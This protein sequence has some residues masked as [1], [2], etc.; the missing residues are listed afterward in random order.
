MK[1]SLIICLLITMITSCK[2]NANS[3]TNNQTNSINSTS[4]STKVISSSSI[5]NSSSYNEEIS[6]D[7]VVTK[8]NEVNNKSYT[9]NYSYQ[10]IEFNDVYVPDSYYYN[11]LFNQGEILIDLVSNTKYLYDF[12]IKNSKVNITNQSYNVTGVQGNTNLSK[13]NLSNFDYSILKENL[14]KDD[15]GI[16][17][18]NQELITFF[19]EVINDSNSFDYIIFNKINDNLIIDFYFQDQ[20]FDGYSYK[21]INVGNSQ[22]ETVNNYLNTFTK[23]NTKASNTKNIFLDNN[24]VIKGDIYF[25][26]GV[27]KTKF[28]SLENIKI[29]NE[30]NTKYKLE[31]ISN[32]VSYKQYFIKENNIINKIGLD[33]TNNIIS[34][35]TDM[36]ENEVHPNSIKFLNDTYLIDNEYVYLGSE[37]NEVI[38]SLLINSSS[39]I[40]DAWV[41]EI[42]FVIKDNQITQF[43]FTTFNTYLNEE[44]VNFEG[45]FS[46]LNNGV[47]E[48]I[49]QLTPSKDD[50]KIKGLLNSLTKENSNY[51]M[52]SLSYI[53]ETKEE[54]LSGEKHIINFV[55]GVFLDA[56]YRINND[57]SLSLQFANGYSL[58]NDK[59]YSFR[60]DVIEDKIDNVK[61]TDYASIKDAILSLSSEVLYIEDNKIK[62]NSLV[63]DVSKNVNMLEQG[64]LIDPSTVS[65]FF[66]DEKIN[67]ITY[68]YGNSYTS[69]YVE[70][71]IY[72]NE[73]NID[74]N[75][76][77]KLNESYPKES[78]IQELY[79]K[80]STD[81]Y[82]LSIYHDLYDNGYNE[83]AD[84]IPYIPGIE[85]SIEIIWLSD[86]PEGY[87]YLI[88][89]APKDYL[90]NFK[91]ALINVYNYSK[92]NENEYKNINKGLKI[93]IKEDYG[94]QQFY[95]TII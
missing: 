39:I 90:E 81:E 14:T 36:K 15:K 58:H 67:K 9:L 16:I 37:A 68:K 50:A 7:Y 64:M 73:G 22:N 46:I 28:E 1:K 88:S 17:L 61:E 29:I 33:G 91:E 34:S 59:V 38:S 53:D 21:L 84:Y 43:T 20:L 72:H 93:N 40:I 47:I 85:S 8:L 57:S 54:S 18:T 6:I 83:Y 12:K 32:G 74:E 77:T 5:S 4:S 89:D 63:T 41:K 27:N 52:E 3:S 78:D 11:E 51:K 87:Q 95:F 48:N 69:S 25:N 62:I 56:N 2:V 23:L 92:T 10:G 60:Y 79:L 80:D 55:N 70:A 26:N 94:Y 30:N 42:K 45:E 66:E 13:V 75:I 82:V 76:L 44:Y 35:Y 24:N 49:S 19:T 71:S 31:S 65:F 86:Y